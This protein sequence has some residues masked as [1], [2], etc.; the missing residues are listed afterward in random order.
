[1]K[2]GDDE[3]AERCEIECASRVEPEAGEDFG[4]G[5]DHEEKAGEE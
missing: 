4:F 1:M 5:N 2:I 3:R